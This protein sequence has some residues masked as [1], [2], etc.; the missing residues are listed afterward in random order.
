MTAASLLLIVGLATGQAAEAKADK[1]KFDTVDG[2]TLRGYPDDVDVLS[3]VT[4]T[5]V[6]LPGWKSPLRACR[7]YSQLPSEAK[8]LVDLIEREVG[9]PVSIIGVGPGRDEC[10]VRS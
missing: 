6:S 7:S 10:V 2:V 8:A 5:Y 1:V 9:V 3:R 4:P